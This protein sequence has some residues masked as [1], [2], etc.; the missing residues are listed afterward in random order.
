MRR[1]EL[2]RR[3][4]AL[5]AGNQMDW[6]RALS[7]LDVRSID[8]GTYKRNERNYDH[9]TFRRG[10]VDRIHTGLWTFLRNADEIVQAAPGLC[11]LSITALSQPEWGKD[12]AGE[13]ITQFSRL[14]CL[15][16]LKSLKLSRLPDPISNDDGIGPK[17][18]AVLAASPH[19]VQLKSL[20]LQSC[21]IGQEGLAAITSSSSF[22]SLESLNLQGCGM[23]DDGALTIAASPNV[24]SLRSLD[25][26][27]NKFGSKGVG[28]LARSEHLK[29]LQRL[30]VSC[31]KYRR[32]RTRGTG[33]FD[34]PY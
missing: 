32:C 13:E 5:L 11:E 27:W 34:L 18:T 21:P 9:C 6:L 23:G 14:H 8:V 25:L 3:E 16:Q 22:S 30:N 20:A 1:V 10:F 33:R 31:N 17:G 19:L 29:N 12:V 7:S 28:E 26:G 15:A 2:Y 24:S 4:R